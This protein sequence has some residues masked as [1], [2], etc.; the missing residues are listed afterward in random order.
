MP[1][2]IFGVRGLARPRTWIYLVRSWSV[3]AVR[4]LISANVGAGLWSL[5]SPNPWEAQQAQHCSGLPSLPCVSRSGRYARG[6]I[7]STRSQYRIS[8][9]PA[10]LPQCSSV[11]QTTSQ[12]LAATATTAPTISP[13]LAPDLFKLPYYGAFKVRFWE[14][15]RRSSPTVRGA[16]SVSFA[17]LLASP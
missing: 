11:P 7:A 15:R 9:S 3:L 12:A 13:P 8:K 10:R 1:M 2:A 5:N 6:S 4:T 16:D 17:F 14:L